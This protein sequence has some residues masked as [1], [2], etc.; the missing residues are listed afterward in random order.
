MSDVMTTVICDART[1]TIN[2]KLDS[3]QKRQDETVV[4][5][6][7]ISK[8]VI[9]NGEAGLIGKVDRLDTRMAVSLRWFFAIFGLVAATLGTVIGLAIWIAQ[10]IQL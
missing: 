10:N 4:D 8:I 6:N 9:G 5:V 2:T 7:K 1:A 3:I